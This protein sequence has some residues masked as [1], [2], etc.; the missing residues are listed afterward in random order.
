MG[1]SLTKVY[2]ALVETNCHRECRSEHL[3]RCLFI[4]AAATCQVVRLESTAVMSLSWHSHVLAFPYL[5]HFFNAK[6]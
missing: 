6:M 5:V 3:R 2:T 1:A 4:F